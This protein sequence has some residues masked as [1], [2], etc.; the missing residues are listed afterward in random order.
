MKNKNKKIFGEELIKKVLLGGNYVTQ[1]DLDSAEKYSQRNDF[2]ILDYLFSNE[3]I[4]KDIFGQAMAEYY[5]IPYADLN[6][7][8]PSMEQVFRIP[9]ELVKEYRAVLFVYEAD[10]IIIATDKPEKEGLKEVMS[11]GLKNKNVQIAYS[12]SEDIDKVLAKCRKPLETRFSKIIETGEKIAPEIIDEIIDDSLA[13]RASDIHFEPQKEKVK[14]RFRVDGLLREAGSIPKKYYENILN[15]I[16]VQ[17]K[18]RI[19]SHFSSQDG[20]IRMIKNNKDIDLRVSIV[21]TLRGEKIVIRV[22]AEYVKGFNLGDLGLSEKDQATINRGLK[23]PFGMI[24]VTGPTGSGKTTTLYALLQKINSPEINITTIEDPVEYQLMGLNQIQVNTETDL[25]FSKGLRSI[26]RQDPDVILVGEIRD[27]ETVEI[28]INAALTG[29]L[30][31]STFHTNDAATAIPRLLD[32]KAEP[33][34]LASTLEMIVAQRLV[35]KICEK[36]RI[37]HIVTKNELEEKVPGISDYIEEDEV[38]L[39]RGQGCENCNQSGFSGRSAI[40]EIIEISDK[41]QDLI[42]SNP[43]SNKIWELAKEQGSRTLFEDGIEKVRNGIT[44]F[45]ELSRVAS[46]PKKA[47]NKQT[48]I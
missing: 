41:M 26:V 5:K 40:F 38:T 30:L 33:F 19:D 17:A 10:K 35:R 45:E 31:L 25:T 1:K 32:M 18:L 3:I 43:S 23:N 24:L 21:P 12:L 4:T 22:L 7:N 47:K 14:V 13:F 48:I 37:S 2:S 36:C 29:H 34:L 15:R 46:L 8:F 42:L 44:T 6:S 28:A 11:Q 16:K 9:I 20:S 27:N 39:Y